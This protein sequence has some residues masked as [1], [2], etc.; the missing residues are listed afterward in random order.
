MVRKPQDR[1]RRTSTFQAE[2][3]DPDPLHH[4]NPL[5]TAITPFEQ[6]FL[7]NITPL[8]VGLLATWRGLNQDKLLCL[9]VHETTLE[10]ESHDLID[11]VICQCRKHTQGGPW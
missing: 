5:S 9:I 2:A 10:Q 11:P 7:L 1:L 3:Q 8:D 4:V 6:M